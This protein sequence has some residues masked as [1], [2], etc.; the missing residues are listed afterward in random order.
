MSKIN[1]MLFLILGQQH[2]LAESSIQSQLSRFRRA[3]SV[4]PDSWVTLH[5]EYTGYTFRQRE[6]LNVTK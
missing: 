2:P 4:L 6:C 5:S 3:T 1:T